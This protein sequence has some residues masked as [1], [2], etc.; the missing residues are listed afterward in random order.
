MDQ[1]RNTMNHWW[2]HQERSGPHNRCVFFQTATT[3]YGCQLML[4]SDLAQQLFCHQ[5]DMSQVVARQVS[6]NCSMHCTHWY[7]FQLLICAF[8]C[9]WMPCYICLSNNIW[10]PHSKK[11]NQKSN[12]Y[13]I[14][15][16]LLCNLPFKKCINIFAMRSQC[17][18]FLDTSLFIIIFY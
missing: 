8:S 18:L 9:Q 14:P 7:S 5:H 4:L 3:C 13:E 10:V 1:S 16:I 2:L 12:Q 15:H 17:L 11:K 6:F